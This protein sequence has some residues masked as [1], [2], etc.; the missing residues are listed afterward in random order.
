MAAQ[1]PGSTDQ[2]DSDEGRGQTTEGASN[3]IA[4]EDVKRKR[5]AE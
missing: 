3:A 5:E 2:L 1:K 4:Q